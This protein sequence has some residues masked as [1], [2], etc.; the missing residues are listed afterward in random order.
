MHAALQLVF[1][2]QLRRDAITRP[3]YINALHLARADAQPFIVEPSATRKHFLHARFARAQHA[4]LF[5]A[6]SVDRM[7]PLNFTL[8]FL[9]TVHLQ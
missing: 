4:P 6:R 9:S 8:L 1:Q 2:E 7:R 5:R 3:N